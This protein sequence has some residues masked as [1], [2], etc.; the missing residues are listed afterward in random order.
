MYMENNEEEI[1]KGAVG[2]K[3]K[4]HP[5][6][7][8]GLKLKD[9]EVRQQAYIQY[10]AHIA[11]GM[12]KESFVF[13]HREHSVTWETMDRYIKENPCEFPAILMQIAR[14]KRYEFW[15]QEG[16]SLMRGLYK[17]GSPVVWQTI[18]R[19]MF[20]AEGWDREQVARD[21][22]PHVEQLAAAIRNEPISETEASDSDE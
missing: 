21:Q 19:N 12:P 6:N 10:C 17:G 2:H 4:G 1:N 13:D 18:M 20:K 16:I 8:H 5:G 7:K 11:S 3:S 9:L 22:K 15:L 14:A